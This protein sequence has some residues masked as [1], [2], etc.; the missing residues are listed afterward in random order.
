MDKDTAEKIIATVFATKEPTPEKQ[1]DVIEE[2]SNIPE[3]SNE[4]VVKNS[5]NELHQL[6]CG[7]FGLDENIYKRI[8]GKDSHFI[9]LKLSTIYFTIILIF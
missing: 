5:I 4:V 2:V 1:I 6:I 8:V 7:R 3:D 9:F